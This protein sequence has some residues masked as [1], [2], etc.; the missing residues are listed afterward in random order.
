MVFEAYCA[1]CNFVHCHLPP[2][3]PPPPPLPVWSSRDLGVDNPEEEGLA[4]TP[5]DVGVARKDTEPSP[6][7]VG[8][9]DGDDIEA[10]YNLQ[11]Y[12]SEEGK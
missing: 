10:L 12:D 5:T 6:G 8:E 7:A 11:H 4:A 9:G 1:M 2:P 3:P